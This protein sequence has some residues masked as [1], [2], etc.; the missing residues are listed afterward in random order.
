MS[1]GL[2]YQPV[3]KSVV[4]DIHDS[5]WVDGT[6]QSGPWI[7]DDSAKAYQGAVQFPQE[8]VNL[9]Y[10]KV[11]LPEGAGYSTHTDVIVESPI[12]LTGGS[13]SVNAYMSV[14]GKRTL[15]FD[16]SG[17]SR[18]FTT[19]HAV[20]YFSYDMSVKKGRLTDDDLSKWEFTIDVAEIFETSV[21]AVSRAF[22]QRG[23]T[24]SW[25]YK[26]VGNLLPHFGRITVGIKFFGM[27]SNF[28]YVV[29]GAGNVTLDALEL[30]ARLSG[31]PR[32]R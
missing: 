6:V 22:F 12:Y 21:I 27:A 30:N 14:E 31:A 5:A 26:I 24:H 23:S 28:E 1:M 4:F 32:F 16:F 7:S 8:V 11:M 29:E 18:Y 10:S 19:T 20:L 15:T 25:I 9:T 3:L 17:F 2:W 13:Y